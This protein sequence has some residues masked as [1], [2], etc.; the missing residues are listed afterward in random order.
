MATHAPASAAPRG[1]ARGE[2]DLAMSAA[3]A[4]NWWALAIRGVLAILFGLVAILMPVP[5]LIS[6]A[7]FFAAYL[8]VD[9]I[10]AIVAAVRAVQKHER[11]GLLLA[12]GVVDILMGG[13][14]FLFPAGAVLGFVVATAA[15][16]LVTGVL[17]LV[18]AF[19]LTR[20]YGRWW[21]VLSGIVS[22][23][24]AVA[25][26]VAP[27][28]GAVVLT[29]WLGAYAVAFGVM[30]LVLSFQLRGRHG[31]GQPARA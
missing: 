11:W 18:A 4:Q 22:I 1:P 20:S 27:L 24:F 19:K 6:L 25:L 26:I 5:T 14:V 15:W 28:L 29:W 8:V 31:S 13:I 10:F 9:G 16:S 12:E 17:M 23:L 21:M 2:G 3:L 30:L 7:L